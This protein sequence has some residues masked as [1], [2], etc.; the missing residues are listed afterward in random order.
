[1]SKHLPE[2]VDNIGQTVGIN[3]EGKGLGQNDD[4]HIALETHL[5]QGGQHTEKVGWTDGPNHHENKEALKAIALIQPADIFIIGA[6]ADDRLD[7]SRTVGARQV[8]YNGA[9][10]DNADIVINGADDMAVDENASDRGQ[11]AR[12]NGHDRLQNL[13]KDKEGWSPDAC[14]LDKG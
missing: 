8:K 5:G 2:K 3:H 7:K 6:L 14:L 10:N 9:T 11:G 4:G 1:M 13:Q 12:D